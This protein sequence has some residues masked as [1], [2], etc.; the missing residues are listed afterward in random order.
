MIKFP[1]CLWVEGNRYVY[2]LAVYTALVST[3]GD[4]LLT[5]DREAI[6]ESLVGRSVGGD[7][8]VNL[9]LGELYFDKLTLA[10]VSTAVTPPRTRKNSRRA[11]REAGR[12]SLNAGEVSGENTSLVELTRAHQAVRTQV[13]SICIG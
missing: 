7:Q 12:G 9:L 5:A 4:E 6:S 13:V 1:R 11:Y 2:L 3:D 8:G 10:T